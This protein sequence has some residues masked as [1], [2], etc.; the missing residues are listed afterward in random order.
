MITPENFNKVSKDYSKTRVPV[1]FDILIGCYISQLGA[2]NDKHLIDIGCGAGVYSYP[3]AEHFNKIVGIDK[4]EGQIEEAIAKNNGQTDLSLQFIVGDALELSQENTSFDAGLISLML[5]HLRDE[6]ENNSHL[7][8]KVIEEVYRLL[9]PGG[10][11][12]IAGCSKSQVYD[13]AWYCNLVPS[14]I[15]DARI[16]IHPTIEYLIS[17]STK[18]G[19]TFDGRFVQTDTVLQGKNYFNRLGPL[20]ESWR[21]ADSIFSSLSPSELTDF[22]TKIK[23][24]EA[25]GVLEDL[26]ERHEEVRKNI[27]QVTFLKFI[28]T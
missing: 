5:H 20:E 28:K 18:Y 22:I 26:V 4:S 14:R 6:S 23:T 27:G 10:V 17:E 15:P 9:K 19:F 11:L 25:Q 3:L 2:L 21:N 8:S 16:K 13:G 24:L 7:Q 1:G 12:M